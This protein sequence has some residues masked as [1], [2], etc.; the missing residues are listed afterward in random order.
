MAT[1]A[2]PI[3]SINSIA[4]TIDTIT[5]AFALV[6][7]AMIGAG[8]LAFAA[9]AQLP[10]RRAWVSGAV[11]IA[12]VIALVMLATAG[13]YGAGNHNLSDLMLFATGVA[14]LPAWLIWTGRISGTGDAHPDPR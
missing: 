10:W 2:N 12:V 3:Q 8:M 1:H 7:F 4:F 9:A 6:A 5:T 13:S 14:V 11:V